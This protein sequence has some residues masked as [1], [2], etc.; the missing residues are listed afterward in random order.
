MSLKGDLSYLRS[1]RI[2]I[3]ISVLLFFGTA[4]L[5]YI[6]AAYD[7]KFADTWLQ[8]LDAL[9]WI[10][11]LSPL[12]I[13]VVIFAKNLFSCILS[14]LLG[15]GIGLVPMI[16][17]TSNGIL[18]GVV[19][20]NVIQKDGPLY[21]LAGIVPHGIIELPVVLICVAM[22]M[23]LGHLFIL[24]VL[25]ERSDLSGE[26]RMAIHLLFK[27]AAPLLLLAAV[28]ESFITPLILSVVP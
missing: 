26:T 13:M 28:I 20:Y 19:A 14:V 24:A 27:R 18:L 2:Y 22:G 8:S 1:I 5:G 25:K 9:R 3:L 15:L 4:I 21:L 23:R 12:M 6:A 7:P 10:R 16:V 11:D 17:A